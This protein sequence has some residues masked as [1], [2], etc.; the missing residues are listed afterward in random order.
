[1]SEWGQGAVKYL[2][3]RECGRAGGMARWGLLR[4]AVLMVEDIIDYDGRSSL[5]P[6]QN[7]NRRRRWVDIAG[8]TALGLS[9][10]SFHPLSV[11][12]LL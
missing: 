11:V 4:W 3:H 8:S 2:S 1:M 12:E 6:I 7:R 5:E 9:F 10:Y